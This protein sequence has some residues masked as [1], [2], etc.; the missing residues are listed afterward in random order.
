M[1]KIQFNELFPYEYIRNYFHNRKR[2]VEKIINS[3]L[4][5]TIEKDKYEKV[6]KNEETRWRWIAINCSAR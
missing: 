5:D 3:E 2:K 6:D 1:K 4:S